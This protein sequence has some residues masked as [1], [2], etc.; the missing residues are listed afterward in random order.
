MPAF[1]IAKVAASLNT[2][3][4]GVP[5]NLGGSLRHKRRIC[6]FVTQYQ[7]DW[8]WHKDTLHQFW[9]KECV[10]IDIPTSFTIMML[11]EEWFNLA[12]AWN[13]R[14]LCFACFADSN[15]YLCLPNKL[16]N[17]ERRSLDNFISKACRRGEKSSLVALMRVYV[18]F[19]M[20]FSVLLRYVNHSSVH[21]RCSLRSC[22]IPSPANQVL[23]NAQSHSWICPM[24]CRLLFGVIGLERGLGYWMCVPWCQAQASLAW[25][26]PVGQRKK[27]S[28]PYFKLKS[29]IAKFT[30]LIMPVLK[31]LQLVDVLI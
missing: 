12:A 4:M 29:L 23:C 9:L 6:G 27:K 31:I 24:V 11:S 20:Y 15:G 17:N 19:T 10:T 18:H 7:G 21:P 14:E 1:A 13:A 2:L 3:F 5:Y 30:Y 8:K 16:E 22:V 28:A 25:L 26:H